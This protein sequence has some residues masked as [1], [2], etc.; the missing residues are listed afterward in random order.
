MDSVWVLKWKKIEGQRCTKARLCVRGFKDLQSPQLLTYAATASRWGQ[1]AI[2][3]VS[4]QMGWPIGSA[5]VGQACLKGLTFEEIAKVPGETDRIVQC[6][7]PRGSVPVLRQLPGYQN[8]DA[9]EEVLDMLRPGFGLKDAPRAWDLRLSTELH[10]LGLRPTQ[11]DRRVYVKHSSGERSNRLASQPSEGR[12]SAGGGGERSSAGGNTARLVLLV[13]THV[14]DLT[15]SE[16]A[17][18]S[19]GVLL[20]EVDCSM[21][22]LGELRCI[23][24]TAQRHERGHQPVALCREASTHLCR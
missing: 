2:C 23:P 14:D 18:F 1:R 3:A 24:H 17:P 12:S 6:E 15:G 8:F 16:A 19:P 4:A 22:A 10:K 9:V 20:W 13:S 7:L 5:D 21:A 11:A